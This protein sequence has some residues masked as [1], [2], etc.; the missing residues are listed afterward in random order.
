ME[1]VELA[2]RSR[3][4]QQTPQSQPAIEAGARVIRKLTLVHEAEQGT[5]AALS[6]VA[7]LTRVRIPVDD[8]ERPALSS[9]EGGIWFDGFLAFFLPSKHRKG[10]LLT[11]A[12]ALG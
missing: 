1:R 12:E 2:G 10:L 8:Q 11:V 7:E 4:W 6:I 5:V 9:R 3:D